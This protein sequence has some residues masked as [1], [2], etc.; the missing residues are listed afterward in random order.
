MVYGLCSLVNQIFV[1]GKS[2]ESFAVAI[3]VPNMDMLR[4]AMEP[5]LI[6]KLSNMSN[7]GLTVLATNSNAVA[8][9]ALVPNGK[10]CTS[11]KVKTMT[12]EE[13]CQSKEAC[14]R[15]L[16]ELIKLGKEKGLKGFEQVKFQH[17]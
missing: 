17:Y 15:M 14:V 1:D 9:P 12:D 6:A 4:L 16:T 7:G 5:K 2:S 8:N 13:L 3:C 11:L 10:S